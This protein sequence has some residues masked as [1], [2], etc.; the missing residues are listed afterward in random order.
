MVS[1][2]LLRLFSVSGADGLVEENHT[3]IFNVFL[4]GSYWVL[5]HFLYIVIFLGSRFS[6]ASLF[7]KKILCVHNTIFASPF[8]C[9]FHP[10]SLTLLVDGEPKL[11]LSL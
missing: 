2:V 3:Y 9:N 1:S 11:S 7:L 5:L 10:L 6:L 8:L 4:Y